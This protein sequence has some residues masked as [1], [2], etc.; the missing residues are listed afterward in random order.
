MALLAAPKAPFWN[1]IPGGQLWIK[2][3]QSFEK[4]KNIVTRTPLYWDLQTPAMNFP[5][6]AVM[7]L[8][9]AV[10]FCLPLLKLLNSF[11]WF[12]DLPFSWPKASLA[13]QIR[14]LLA[15]T[16]YLYV[17]SKG[18]ENFKEKQPQNLFNNDG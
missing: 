12:R 6:A 3:T 14:H 17:D 16:P 13:N 11:T 2:P 7:H 18:E 15:R 1:S 4:S 8:H 9:D 5:H 10:T